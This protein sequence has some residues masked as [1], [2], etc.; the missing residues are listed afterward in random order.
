LSARHQAPD[1]SI[2]GQ[3]FLLYRNENVEKNQRSSIFMCYKLIIFACIRYE[4][5]FG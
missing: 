4:G 5:A 1:L 2:L 3:G